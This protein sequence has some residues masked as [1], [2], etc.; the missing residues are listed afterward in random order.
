MADHDGAYK[1][2]FSQPDMVAAL[3]RL[4]DEPKWVA[5]L[6][7]STLERVNSAF[8]SEK[9]QQRY[10]DLIWRVRRR[11]EQE[12][13]HI[14]LVLELQSA[15]NR[16]MAVRF[17]A[18]VWLL[19]QDLIDQGMTAP[20]GELPPVLALLVYNGRHRWTAPLE[21]SQLIQSVPG[22]K[23]S[24]SLEYILLD[25]VRV[26]RKTP[27]GAGNLAMSLFRLESS[28]T[29]EELKRNLDN[30]I[31]LLA[32]TGKAHLRGIFA[33]WLIQ[34]LLPSRFP[35][36]QVNEVKSLTEVKTMLEETVLD[37]TLEWKKEGIE[38]GKREGIREGRLQLLLE[39]LQIKFGPLPRNWK[40]RI[41]AAD[42][43]QHLAWGRRLLTA[44]S[45]E[46][47]LQ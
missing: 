15:V 42:S 28:R 32:P 14:Y 18:Y 4:L 8:V 3:L 34:V 10:S 5:D 47:A 40:A 36:L 35:G 20:S 11:G 6:D 16:Y 37:W 30:L 25:A 29:L 44:D 7:F 17:N 45:L 46:Q 24:R 43:E 22:V 31:T 27:R 23:K 33:E 26:A 39:Q 19:Y 1:R 9:L 13:L 38:E 12:W 21:A 41:A 2:F